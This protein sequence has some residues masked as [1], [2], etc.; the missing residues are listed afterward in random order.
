MSYAPKIILHCP[1]SSLAL[2]HR[3]VEACL[4]DKVLLIS[5]VGEGC[6]EIEDL[7]DEIVVGD[8]S[9]ESRFITTTSHKDEALED[10]LRFVDAW[11]IDASVSVQQVRI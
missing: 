4:R 8:G 2:L 9:D 1:V 5:V 6:E 7:I 10:V 11:K 3:F